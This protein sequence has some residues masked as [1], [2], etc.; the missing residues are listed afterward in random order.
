MLGGLEVGFLAGLRFLCTTCTIYM[1]SSLPVC[2]LQAECFVDERYAVCMADRL[3]LYPDTDSKSLVVWDTDTQQRRGRLEG[4]DQQVRFV[5]A[6]GSLAFSSQRH[7]AARLWNLETMRCT[8]TLSDALGIIYSACCDIRGRVLLGST[9]TI[10]VWDAA[11]SAPAPLPDLE[12]HTGLVLSI[13]A[14]AD[15]ALSGSVDKTVRLWDLRTGQ[16]VRTMEGHTGPIFSVD[17]DCQCRTAVSGSRDKTVKLWDLGS[18][19]CI[20]TYE[21]HTSYVRDVVMHE[22]GSSFLSADIAGG[23]VINAW[24]VGSAK[25]TM[26]A[27]MSKAIASL[28]PAGQ[29]FSH[30][31]FAS[32]DLASVTYCTMVGTDPLK[33]YLKRW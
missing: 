25:A 1:H 32:R 12:G 14:S 31:M 19:R 8:A 9:G 29:P 26:R 13:K 33:I 6:T 15:T 24:A 18:G 21:G 16:S 30:R 4:H 3:F 23:H 7:G 22:S 28:L 11:A 5:E 20:D 2:A 17:M 10:K 27:D